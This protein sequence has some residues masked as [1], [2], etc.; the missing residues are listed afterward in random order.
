MVEKKL[1]VKNFDECL[2]AY[3]QHVEQNLTPQL[4]YSSETIAQ[5]AQDEI[6]QWHNLPRLT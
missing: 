5:H 2:S 6:E 4:T 1:L 3:N